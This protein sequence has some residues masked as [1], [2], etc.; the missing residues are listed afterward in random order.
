MTLVH[1]N[2]IA[3]QRGQPHVWTV[4]NRLGC[5]NVKGVDIRC[6]MQTRFRPNA[7][8]PRAVFKGLAFVEIKGD[9]AI[10]T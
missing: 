3:M 1:F 5:F 10:L 7:R 6:P 9:M 4:H 8:Q 2:R